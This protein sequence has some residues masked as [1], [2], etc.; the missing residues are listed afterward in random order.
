MAL[1][2]TF[3][4]HLQSGIALLL[5]GIIVWVGSTLLEISNSNARFEE[6]I[7]NLT[8]QISELKI[9][10]AARMHDRFTGKEGAAHEKRLSQHEEALKRLNNVV[11]NHERRLDRLEDLG[12]SP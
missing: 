9:T 6:R 1:T 7:N 3:E 11:D 10:V 8:N 12:G 2:E 5:V 4:R